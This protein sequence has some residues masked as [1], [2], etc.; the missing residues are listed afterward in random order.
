MA[1]ISETVQ[2]S[3][4]RRAHDH[5]GILCIGITSKGFS[6]RYM[7]KALTAAMIKRT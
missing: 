2:G 4:T 6:S 1:K 5:G 7:L 3:L